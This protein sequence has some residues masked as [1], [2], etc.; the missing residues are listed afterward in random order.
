MPKGSLTFDPG[1]HSS[2]LLE[3]R[4][5]WGGL[6]KRSQREDPGGQRDKPGMFLQKLVVESAF[7]LQ[8]ADGTVPA[9]DTQG[10]VLCCP[11]S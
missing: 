8:G 7:Q 3:V 10:L 11:S 4:M 5:G 6:W 2:G 9:R 1:T